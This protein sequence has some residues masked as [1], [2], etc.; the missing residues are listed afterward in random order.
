M[1]TGKNELIFVILELETLSKKNLIKLNQKTVKTYKY[2]KYSD[3]IKDYLSIKSQIHKRHSTPLHY[4]KSDR[5]TFKARK[6]ETD[7]VMSLLLIIMT[8]A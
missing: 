3:V 5:L 6:N 4:S 2:K 1:L 8:D 7:P